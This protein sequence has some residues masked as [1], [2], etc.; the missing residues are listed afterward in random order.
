MGP[1]SSLESVLS[2]KTATVTLAVQ[3]SADT[4]GDKGT[5]YFYFGGG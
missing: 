4:S 5:F 3:D 1:G 2:S